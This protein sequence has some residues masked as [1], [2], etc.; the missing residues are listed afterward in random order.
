[1]PCLVTGEAAAHAEADNS[2]NT[3][4]RRV[5][6]DEGRLEPLISVQG[7]D[8]RTQ[9]RVRCSGACQGLETSHMRFRNPLKGVL[10][11]LSEVIE[12]NHLS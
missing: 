12:N 3:L 6:P 7:R 10:H 11:A 5:R 9:H 1:M 2:A 4:E 8:W